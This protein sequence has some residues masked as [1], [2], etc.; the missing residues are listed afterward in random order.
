MSHDFPPGHAVEAV[1]DVRLVL[2][3]LS[4]RLTADG[5]WI[6]IIGY[7]AKVNGQLPISGVPT[8]PSK[9]RV[10]IEAILVWSAGSLDIAKYEESL[11]HTKT[12]DEVARKQPRL[13]TAAQRPPP[14]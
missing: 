1:V 2:E 14:S 11:T 13:S 12:I 9:L 5:A 3:K 8:D 7:L 4:G 10:D 6:N